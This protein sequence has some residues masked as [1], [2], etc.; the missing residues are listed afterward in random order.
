MQ[1][2]FTPKAVAGCEAFLLGLTASTLYAVF[3]KTKF[4]LVAEVAADFPIRVLARLLVVRDAD[5]Y[6]LIDWGN[7]IVGNTDPEHTD[8]LADSEES[9]K[10]R[11]LPFRSPVAQEV[12]DDGSELACQR[13]GRDGTKFVPRLVNGAP[14]SVRWASR[15]PE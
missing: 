9:E 3:A 13:R 5:T 6:K 4:D 10:Y 11:L 15:L 7:R 8:V 12:F 14:E 2:E 1:G